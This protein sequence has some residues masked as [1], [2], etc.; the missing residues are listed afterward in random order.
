MHT[1]IYRILFY[2]KNSPFL[3]F[4]MKKLQEL[5]CGSELQNFTY[6]LYIFDY[7]YFMFQSMKII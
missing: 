5:E 3:L 1:A 4:T 6:T 2:S 7:L